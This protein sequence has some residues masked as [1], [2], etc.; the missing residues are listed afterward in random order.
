M[1]SLIAKIRVK[2]NLDLLTNNHFPCFN[3]SCYF[4]GN[5]HLGIGQSTDDK[6]NQSRDIF[7]IQS[8]FIFMPITITNGGRS[9][10]A[11]SSSHSSTQEGE[12]F[13]I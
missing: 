11:K 7:N 10:S 1:I 12:M 2:M 8:V 9:G 4:I 6:D 5:S 13:L 3:I